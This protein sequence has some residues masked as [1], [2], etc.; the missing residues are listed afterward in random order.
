[1]P[2]PRL[3]LPYIVQGQAQ[4]EVTHN[5]ALNTLDALVN[6]YVLDRDLTAPPGSPQDGDTYIVAASATGAWA[7]QD[8]KIAFCLDGAWR[9]Y[10]PIKGLVAYVADEQTLLVQT[11]A[12]WVDLSTILSLQNV[13]KLGVNTTAD[14]TNRLAIKSTAALF[15]ALEAANG[16]TDDIHVVFNKN[17]TDKDAAFILQ[18]GF[19]TRALIGLL[20]DDNLT[21][22]VSPDGSTFKTGFTVDK[23]TGAVDHSQGV[24]FSATI[25]FN[26]YHNSSAWEKVGFNTANHNDWAAFS[27]SNSN[28]TAPLNGYYYLSASL[29]FK[30]NS[31]IPTTMN[32]AL[33]LNN[34]LLKYTEAGIGN[35]VDGWSTVNTAGILKLSAGDVV[36]VRCEFTGSDG[37][38]LGNFSRFDGMRIS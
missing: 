12:A 33:F 11:G 37:Y 30:K 5:D 24:K 21:L 14:S 23:S 38:V 26:D 4:K 20:G 31:A 7:A 17:A 35:P 25:N 28:F 3:G 36:D 1:M 13:P 18:N 34:T 22:K 9:F 8:G 16:G 19:S 6:L 15:A 32:V 27:A 10:V 29:L 2:T